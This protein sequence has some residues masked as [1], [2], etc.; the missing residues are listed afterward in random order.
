MHLIKKILHFCK[1]LTG[2]DVSEC[3]PNFN[4]KY[5][6]IGPKLDI[7]NVSEIRAQCTHESCV[8]AQYLLVMAFELS[9][10][11]RFFAKLH[12]QFS[13]SG[14]QAYTCCALLFGI[15]H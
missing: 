14:F 11:S 3:R 5:V 9:I 10:K 13:D 8:R 2:F 1:N 7:S 6:R 15:T 4:L 12:S